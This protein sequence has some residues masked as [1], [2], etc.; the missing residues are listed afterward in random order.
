ME[1]SFSEPG[2]GAPTATA[3][4]NRIPVGLADFK[5]PWLTLALLAILIAI[6]AIENIFSIT[7]G[8]GLSPS[9][10][11]LLAMGGLSRTAVLSDG[12]WYRLFTAPL[13]H[14]GPIH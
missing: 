6:F 9:V 1:P 3:P 14:G 11:T 5:W 2:G 10:G 12:E 7:P 8:D 13:L 4:P